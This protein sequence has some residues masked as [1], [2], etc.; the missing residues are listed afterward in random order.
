MTK[1]CQTPGDRLYSSGWSESNVCLSLAGGLRWSV[2]FLGCARNAIELPCRL[3][4]ICSKGKNLIAKNNCLDVINSP[5]HL[6]VIKVI[7]FTKAEFK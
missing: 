2:L 4:L 5:N 3:N 7:K 6:R 1:L